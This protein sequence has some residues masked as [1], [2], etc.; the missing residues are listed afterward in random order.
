[1][2]AAVI[3]QHGGPGCIQF[4]KN[5]P[6]PR[7]GPDDVILRV[8]ACSLNYH[9][10]FTRRGMPGI[11]IPLPCIMGNDFS[12]DIVEL[13]ANVKDWA[14]GNRVV[15][16]P[17]D[18]VGGGGMIGEM[19]HGGMAE[20]CRVPVAHLVRV[21]DEV[22]YEHAAVL[23]VAYGAAYRMMFSNGDVQPKDKI[24]I[25][26]ASGGVG[27]CC[28]LFCKMIG[29]QVVATASSAAKIERLRAMGVDHVIDTSSQDFVKEIWRI[30]TKPHRRYFTGGVDVVVNYIGGDTWVQS[31]KVV[32][33]GGK[34][35]TCGAA[36]GFAPQEDLR[37]IW[38]F[39]IK[40]LGSNGWMREDLEKL[41][42]LTRSKKLTP[43]IEHRFKLDQVNEAFRLMEDRQLFG[44]IVLEP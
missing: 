44:K 14:V 25:L 18:R 15:V 27:T 39:E 17:I 8:R 9:D 2:R 36:A 4:E 43:L 37:Y 22:S 32:R 33:R 20:Y 13:G 16:D 6:D 38:S 40:V 7:P 21:P 28:V 30:Y 5:F 34:V 26:G 29:A 23:P 31:L 1:M 10:I 3:H 11:K 41:L 12:G 35:L 42:E 24:L 19:W